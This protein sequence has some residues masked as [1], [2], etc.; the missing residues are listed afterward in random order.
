MG[1]MLVI[2]NIEVFPPKSTT[3]PTKKQLYFDL[4]LSITKLFR[5]SAFKNTFYTPP[6]T[7]NTVVEVGPYQS[8]SLGG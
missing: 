6:T 3:H 5:M 4:P 2:L 1:D 8:A 7:R